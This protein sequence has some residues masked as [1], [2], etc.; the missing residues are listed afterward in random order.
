MKRSHIVVSA[1]AAGLI[2]VLSYHTAANSSTGLLATPA[3]GSS[4]SSSGSTST[5]GA[6]P[7][8]TSTPGGAPPSSTTA[9]AS[10]GHAA[11]GTSTVPSTTVAPTTTSPSVRKADGATENYR[12]GTLELQVTITGNRI[13]DVEPV[14]DQATDPRSAQIN[15]QAI[16]MLR[17]QALSAQ[18][19]Q[20][21][22]VSGATYTSAAYQASLQSALDSLG[23]H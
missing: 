15:S 11:S 22:G 1:T 23:F 10:G 18:S 14:V 13:T 7:S 5:S 4:G 2:G 16:P 19:A 8:S 12:Y 3:G 21:D 9:P 20:I 17:Q 6:P